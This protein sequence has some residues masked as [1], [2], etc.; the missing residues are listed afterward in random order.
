[1]LLIHDRDDTTVRVNQSERMADALTDAH[2]DVKF[3]R[4]DGNDHR[5]M[6]ATSRVRM[7]SELEAFLKKNIGN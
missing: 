5:L 6:F 2:K 1:V 7:L 4:L 3:V